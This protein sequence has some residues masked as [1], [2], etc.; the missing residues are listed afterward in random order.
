MWGSFIGGTTTRC[1]AVDSDQIE[2]LN[3][4]RMRHVALKSNQW[5]AVVSTGTQRVLTHLWTPRSH[6][7]SQM[8]VK[9]PKSSYHTYEKASVK[10][11][12]CPCGF[13]AKHLFVFTLE[14]SQYHAFDYRRPN[15]VYGL[16][17]GPCDTSGYAFHGF[18][19]GMYSCI[20]SERPTG[21]N[22]NWPQQR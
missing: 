2:E 15:Q 21:Q 18:L 4:V 12:I 16:I 11:K 17:I 9:P 5:K 7:V 6:D 13:I 20:W 19:V 1:R 3:C 14:V 22:S 10:G 8:S